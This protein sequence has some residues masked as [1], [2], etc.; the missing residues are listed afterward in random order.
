MITFIQIFRQT[1]YQ[2]GP[3]HKNIDPVHTG[4][5]IPLISGGLWNLA[6]CC[7]HFPWSP[8]P[9]SIWKT[10]LLISHII[11]VP[12]GHS[13]MVAKLLIQTFVFPVLCNPAASPLPGTTWLE[14]EKR[15]VWWTWCEGSSSIAPSLYQRELNT[16]PNALSLAERSLYIEFSPQS[17]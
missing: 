4:H 8:I 11:P 9:Q 1:A 17:N 13:P 7:K 5:K 16:T 2:S 6:H 15:R 3:H 10:S 14:L 12:L